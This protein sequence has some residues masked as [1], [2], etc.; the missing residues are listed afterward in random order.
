MYN[1]SLSQKQSY[2]EH[3]WLLTILVEAHILGERQEICS[4]KQLTLWK[5]IQKTIAVCW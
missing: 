4:L 5:N 2:K 1:S 3:K